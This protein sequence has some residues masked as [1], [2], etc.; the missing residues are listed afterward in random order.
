MLLCL[1]MVWAVNGRA[2][3]ACGIDLGADQTICAGESITLHGP[4]GYANYLWSTG[5]TTQDITVSAAGDYWCQVSYP[6]GELVVNGDFSAGNTGFS[7]EYTFTY[8]N[9]QQE[10]MYT[11]GPNANWYHPQ[12]EGTGDGNFLIAN[13]GW[14]AWVNGVQDVWCQT[15]D[16]CPGQTYTLGFDGLTLSNETPGRALWTA[17]GAIVNWPDFT[18]P[19]FNNGWATFSTSWT[20]SSTQGQVEVC[21]HITSANGVGDDMGFDNISMEGT[22]YLRDTVR[23]VVVPLPEVDLGPDLTLCEGGTV[24]LDATVLNGSYEWQDG[25][26]SPV[27][28]V[29]G[30]GAYGVTVTANGCSATGQVNV[31][32][33]PLPIV[34]LGNDTTLCEGATLEL[35]PGAMGAT[36]LWQDGSTAPSHTVTGPGEYWVQAT[37]NGCAASDTISVGQKPMPVVD[38]GADTTLCQGDELILDATVPGATYLWQDGTT[39]PTLAVSAA[40]AYQVSVD[41]N[42]CVTDDQLLVSVNPVP[43]V[44]LGPDQSICPGTQ[45]TLDATTPGA[46]YLWNTGATTPALTTGAPGTHTVEVTVDGCSSI[47]S[48]LISHLSVPTVELGG[49][50]AFCADGDTRIGTTIPGAT[51]LWSTGATTDSITV[52]DAGTYWLEV[53]QNGCSN[54][55]TI[56]L[57]V[58][59]LPVVA[60]GGDQQICPGI[61]VTLDASLPGATYLWSN[62]ATTPTVEADQGTWAVDVTAAGCTGTDAV[63]ITG[64]DRPGVDLGADTLLCPG[65]S[66]VLD[67]TWP[68]ATYVWNTGATTPT[69]TV[70][71]PITAIVTLTDANGCTNSDTINVAFGQPGS[72]DLGPDTVLCDNEQLILD[73][74]TPGA[75]SYIWSDG[76]GS[77]TLVAD[78]EGVYWVELDVGDCTV[79]DT[80]EITLQPAPAIS[81][82]NDTMLCPGEALLLQPTPQAGVN[83]VWSDGSQGASLTVEDAGTYQVTATNSMGCSAMASVEIAYLTD[84]AIDLGP[85]TTLCQGEE[86]VLD[87]DL[88]GGTTQWSGASNATTPTIQVSD[89]GQY[90]ATTTVSGCSFSDTVNVQFV[91]P[92]ALQLGNDTTL[93]AGDS[94]VLSAAGASIMWDDGSQAPQRT[95]TQAGTYWATVSAN[96][97]TTTDSI[98]V[99]MV[100]LP[101]IPLG[102]DTLL[103]E[104]EVLPVDLGIAGGSYAWNDGATEAQRDL[105]PGTWHVEVVVAGCANSDT[106]QIGELPVPSLVLPSDTTLCEGEDW[107]I[108]VQQPDASYAW[109]DGSTGPTLLVDMPGTYSVSLSR[110]GCTATATVVVD[111]VDLSQFSLGPDTMLCPGETLVLTSAPYNGS[112]MWQDGTTAPQYTVHQAGTY[113]GTIEAGGCSGQAEIV[114][115]YAS[116]PDIDL[117]GDRTACEGDSLLLEVDPEGGTL[118]WSTGHTG[119]TLMVTQSGAYAATLLQ[120][121]CT[122]SDAVNILFHPVQDVLDLGN[123]GMIC[124]GQTIVLNAF[125]PGGTTQWSD[126]STGPTLVVDAPGTYGATVTGDCI[127]ATGVISFAPGD[128][129]PLVHVPNAFSPDGDGRNEVFIPLVGL[130]ISTSGAIDQWTFR[131][132]NRWGLELFSTHAPGEGWDGRSG[133]AEAPTGVYIWELRYAGHIPGRVFSEHLRGSV[134]LLR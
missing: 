78:D 99:A 42:G 15:I 1:T 91:G 130:A 59:P 71:E 103:C 121:G 72:V 109:T 68:D 79:S 62:G 7:S 36:F 28:N 90:V 94:L 40:G 20:A 88:P 92:P 60:L 132:F 61:T 133:G 55:D 67:A 6:S 39:G 27:F 21:I 102:A 106:I 128:C 66:L 16:I 89:P 52:A 43:L 45:L 58:T 107:L 123:D 113:S 98:V 32:Y 49:D 119:N 23:V 111:V 129:M 115:G 30:A 118:L 75:V 9:L 84:Q 112:V 13:G 26:T 12:F 65:G 31:T 14:T 108:D 70:E 127:L 4:D 100:P 54:A 122:V 110:E 19:G 83:L 105:P 24:Q 77:P 96:G 131:I 25:S 104:G 86:L 11:I 63:T 38:L 64:L 48:V 22:I 97:C 47:A 81:L 51:Y 82:G 3:P 37:Q 120:E 124:A 10:G 56:N 85:D 95:V 33:N 134:T 114:V 5:A 117:G 76:S 35:S 73:A 69:L 93:C 29:S 116:L 53:T 34:G 2:Q 50:H 87:A 17:D 18:F 126:G 46:S 41:L 44:D 80:I 57:S 8:T 74:T 125:I 101:P